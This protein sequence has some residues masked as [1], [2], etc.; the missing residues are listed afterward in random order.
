MNIRIINELGINISTAYL[1]KEYAH[2]QGFYLHNT[3]RAVSLLEECINITMG[4]VEL[5]AECKLEL[6]DIL[7]MRG[8]PWE[9][10]L[11]YFK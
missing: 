11:L 5:Q 7:L 8:D 4:E 6:A 9:A 2:L 3:E 10:I 1:I